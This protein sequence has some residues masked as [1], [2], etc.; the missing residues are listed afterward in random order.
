MFSCTTGEAT[1]EASLCP[2]FKMLRF[3]SVRTARLPHFLPLSLFFLCEFSMLILMVVE[4]QY[5][6]EYS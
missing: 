2:Q 3:V 4:I 6:F 5:V 1:C